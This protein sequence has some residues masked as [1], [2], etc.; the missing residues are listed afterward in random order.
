MSAAMRR[1]VIVQGHDDAIG[2]IC[3]WFDR[4]QTG[5]GRQTW[6]PEVITIHDFRNGAA[7]KLGPHRPSWCYGTPGIARAQQLAAIAVGDPSRTRTA[8]QALIG[9]LTDERQ[10]AHL[11]DA[12]LCHGWAGLVHTARRAVADTSTSELAT[13]ATGAAARMRRHLHASGAPVG[14]GFLEGEAGVAL[15]ETA[16]ARAGPGGAWDTCLLV[17]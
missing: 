1:G 4:W 11:A 16:T 5:Q 3:E 17:S 7:P 15:V 14:A 2:A 12:G 10:L 6:W 13:A 8:E 9:C